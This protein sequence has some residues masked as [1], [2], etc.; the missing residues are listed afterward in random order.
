MQPSLSQQINSKT[1]KL[2]LVL[3]VP[4]GLVKNVTSSVYADSAHKVEIGVSKKIDTKTYGEM[5][6]YE[7]CIKNPELLHRYFIGWEWL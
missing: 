7:V 4:R 6:T 5:E 1:K 3:T 2:E